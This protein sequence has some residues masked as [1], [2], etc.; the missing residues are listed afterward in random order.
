MGLCF[1]RTGIFESYFC[2]SSKTNEEDRENVGHAEC[3]GQFFQSLY[4]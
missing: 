3:E 1:Q 2:A 4:L